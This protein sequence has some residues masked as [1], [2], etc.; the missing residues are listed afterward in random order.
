MNMVSKTGEINNPAFEIYGVNL[1]KIVREYSAYFLPN[2][3]RQTLKKSFGQTWRGVM[4]GWIGGWDTPN[5]KRI[6]MLRYF[7]MFPEV[8]IAITLFLI[9]LP[10]NK[11]LYR[12]YKF[13]FERN[14]S[15][16]FN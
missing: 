16:F 4:V 2:T 5:G 9:P 1:H 8:W 14:S 13:L 10:I 3:I 15:N 7:W 6:K 11:L 12:A